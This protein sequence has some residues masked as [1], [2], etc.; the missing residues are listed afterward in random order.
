M[1]E[2]GLDITPLREM[3]AE[4]LDEDLVRESDIGFGFVTLS[5]NDRKALRLNVEDINPGE[6][7]YY[8]LG[9]AMIPGFT[10]D[11]SFDKKFIDGGLYDNFP[12]KM[13][14]EKGYRK[15]IGVNLFTKKIKPKY[16]DAEVIGIG[17]S[18]N[19]GNILYFNK[20]NASENM[21]LGYLDAMKAFGA[22]KGYEFFFENVP[23]EDEITKSLCT[24][25]NEEK[26]TISKLILRK[27]FKNDKIF[28]E[29][30]LHKLGQELDISSEGSYQ[31]LII[32]ALEK[33]MKKQK[34]GELEIYDFK[35]AI[36][37][38]NEVKINKINKASMI[39]L[40]NLK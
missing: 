34:V 16:K 39:L 19:L 26:D 2:K 27:D 28:Y 37:E 33:I 22:L 5:V 32:L 30:V 7:R 12:L 36:D 21:Q 6:L 23:S 38:L 9:S 24:L 3:I 10:Q 25:S 15:I 18:K 14:Y 40:Q 20:D 31:D 17:P 11:E 8:L 35:E 29:K 4:Y 13:A 1:G